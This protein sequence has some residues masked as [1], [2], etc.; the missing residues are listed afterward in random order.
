MGSGLKQFYVKA[1]TD[2]LTGLAGMV[3]YNLLLSIFPVALIARR[4]AGARHRVLPHLR[5]PCRVG[6]TKLFE[7]PSS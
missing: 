4:S 1:Y 7:H 3:A 6:A 5:R 2:N